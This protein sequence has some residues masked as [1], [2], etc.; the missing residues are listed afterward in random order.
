MFSKRVTKL[1]A[2][3]AQAVAEGS[4]KLK[5]KASSSISTK[6]QSKKSKAA[7]S[8]SNE[9]ISTPSPSPPDATNIQPL[10]RQASVRTEE[11]ERLLHGD[12]IIVDSDTELM[13][14]QASR[15]DVIESEAES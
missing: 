13:K 7:P 14:S 11:E 10:S 2:K 15:A 8:T 12:S 9:S 3:A 6:D 5:R 1:T 4:K